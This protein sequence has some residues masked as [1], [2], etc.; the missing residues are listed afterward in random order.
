MNTGIYYANGFI[1]IALHGRDVTFPMVVIFA[2]GL[3]VLAGA[4][5][6]VIK[7]M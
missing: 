6:L 3:L 5:W 4:I 1:G 2:G 7:M